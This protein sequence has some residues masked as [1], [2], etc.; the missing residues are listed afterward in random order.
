MTWPALAKTVGL[1][2]AVTLPFWNIPL[3][4]RIQQRKS[5]DDISLAWVL[6]AFTC[7]VLM[8]PSALISD[9]LVY[10]AY[11]VVNIFFFGTVVAQ[12]LRFHKQ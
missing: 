12:V 5:S 8:L 7:M 4:I 1:V 6:G 11:S 2:A 10:R 3:I 9:D